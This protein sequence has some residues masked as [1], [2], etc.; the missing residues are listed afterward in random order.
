L[1][2]ERAGKLTLRTHEVALRPAPEV[3]AE[4]LLVLRE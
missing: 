1:A 4:E 3:T 2:N